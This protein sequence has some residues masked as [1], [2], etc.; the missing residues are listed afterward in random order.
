[1]FSIKPPYLVCI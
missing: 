1:M